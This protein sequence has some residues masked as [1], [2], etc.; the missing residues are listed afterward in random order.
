MVLKPVFLTLDAVDS[1]DVDSA[2]DSR[3]RAR[4]ADIEQ[5]GFDVVGGVCV[6]D[7]AFVS[8]GDAM[9]SKRICRNESFLLDDGIKQSVFANEIINIERVIGIVALEVGIADDIVD[10]G[11]DIVDGDGKPDRRA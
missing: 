7:D 3:A 6:N 2:V 1:I 5:R 11:V 4:N 8:V 10:V 9:S